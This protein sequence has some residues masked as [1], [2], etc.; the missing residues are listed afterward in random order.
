MVLC[1]LCNGYQNAAGSLV[2]PRRHAAA[3]VDRALRKIC[4]NVIEGAAIFLRERYKSIVAIQSLS[5]IV[6]QLE[7]HLVD[8][9]FDML[10]CGALGIEGMPDG[11]DA[12]KPRN[13]GITD[14]EHEALSRN[15]QIP[16]GLHPDLMPLELRGIRAAGG[17]GRPGACRP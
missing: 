4:S 1:E 13:S 8:L 17:V 5:A 2:R 16:G 12:L 6:A 3:T 14:L 15:W 10:L 11:G 9:N 7:V